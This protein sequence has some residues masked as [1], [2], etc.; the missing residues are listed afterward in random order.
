MAK[1]NAEVVA[2][3]GA[4]A[5]DIA[6]HGAGFISLQV[7]VSQSWT[8]VYVVPIVRAPDPVLSSGHDFDLGC[9]DA[10]PVLS[11][12]HGAWKPVGDK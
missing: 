12:A 6:R 11:V 5:G 2:A 1:G 9:R 4:G 10:A 8:K 7:R 3:A